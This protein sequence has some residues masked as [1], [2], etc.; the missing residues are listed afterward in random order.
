MVVTWG[1]VTS[2]QYL[3]D[4][5][6]PHMLTQQANLSY[7]DAGDFALEIPASKITSRDLQ[8]RTQKQITSGNF[9]VKSK[10]ELSYIRSIR[11][12]AVAERLACS[13]PTMAIRVHSGFSY[14]RIMPDEAVGQRV[15]SGTSRFFHFGAAPYSPQSPSSAL[16]ISLL[17]AVQISSLS[18]ICSGSQLRHRNVREPASHAESE[19]LSRKYAIFSPEDMGYEVVAMPILHALRRGRKSVKTAGGKNARLPPRR[20]GF[21]P[22]QVESY[23]TI[24]LVGVFSGGSPISPTPS[25]R[26]RSIFTSITLIGSQDL[27]PLVRTVFD[28]SWRTMVQSSPSTVTEDN[29][30]TVDIGIFV[31]KT[32]ESSLQCQK[33]GHLGDFINQALS[34]DIPRVDFPRLNF[35]T[36]PAVVRGMNTTSLALVH[37]RGVSHTYPLQGIT[38]SADEMAVNRGGTTYALHLRFP[39]PSFESVVFAHL[40]EGRHGLCPMANS[41]LKAVHD[42]TWSRND[43]VRQTALGVRPNMRTTLSLTDRSGGTVVLR[44]VPSWGCHVDSTGRRRQV[45]GRHTTS[46]RVETLAR[47]T[48]SLRTTAVLTAAA[49]V[50]RRPRGERRQQG[51]RDVTALFDTLPREAHPGEHTHTHEGHVQA[52]RSCTP[53][54][55]KQTSPWAVGRVQ[56]SAVGATAAALGCQPAD[57]CITSHVQVLDWHACMVTHLHLHDAVAHITHF[58]YTH[59]I[60][61]L[62]L[63]QHRWCY[64]DNIH[65]VQCI[66][67][68]EAA[69]VTVHELRDCDGEQLTPSAK[70]KCAFPDM[71]SSKGGL[72]MEGTGTERAC[73]GDEAVE[74]VAGSRVY[75]RGKHKSGSRQTPTWA[76][77]Q[78][79]SPPCKTALCT[80]GISGD[81][82]HRT[83][84]V[85]EVANRVAAKQRPEGA[86]PVATCIQDEVVDVRVSGLVVAVSMLVVEQRWRR[87]PLVP[88]D[89]L[90]HLREPVEARV[91]RLVGAAGLRRTAEPPEAR[92]ARERRVGNIHLKQPH[93]SLPV[94]LGTSPRRTRDVMRQIEGG[95]TGQS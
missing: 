3:S 62:L 9:L 23:Q 5:Q 95:I 38:L 79:V 82:P 31:H 88:A 24:P 81:V 56:V 12:A 11:R 2:Q 39:S 8:I 28:T 46:M 83:Q 1:P 94:C 21:N 44:R 78:V 29:Q 27:A 50:A 51:R 73:E 41:Q 65:R 91:T 57:A 74:L 33:I 77:C 40:A 4:A 63:Q 25:F 10:M 80:R 16:N 17:R 45:L 35:L 15:F 69:D 32:V 71:R 85:A 37:L 66:S 20:T 68:G 86:G 6:R 14:A 59:A 58:H 53:S 49:P 64:Y 93:C 54:S 26:C 48:Q 52:R 18:P 61:Q 92:R 36:T 90:V 55:A 7:V 76:V 47:A 22:R 75:A 72:V 19:G 60:T 13:P 43:M 42:K 87:H 89:V 30:C 70:Q 84:P 34:K 67:K